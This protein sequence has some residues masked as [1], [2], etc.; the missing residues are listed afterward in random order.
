MRIIPSSVLVLALAT[1]ALA[2]TPGTV[3]RATLDL[4]TL[5]AVGDDSPNVTA[6]FNLRYRRPVAT[7]TTL[8]IRGRLIRREDPHLFL[9]GEIVDAEGQVLTTAEARW[10]RLG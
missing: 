6:D 8:V 10:R 2:Q 7:N 3:E 5:G 4:G 1:S 9:E